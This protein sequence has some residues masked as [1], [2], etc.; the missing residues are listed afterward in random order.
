MTTVEEPTRLV[1]EPVRRVEDA[2]LISGA[3]KYLAD[4]Q[5]PGM[6]HVAI[7]RSP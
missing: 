3:A 5:L 7:L 4:L 6:A 1:G 2:R